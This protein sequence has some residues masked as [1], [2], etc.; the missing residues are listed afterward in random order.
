MRTRVT[1]IADWTIRFYFSFDIYDRERIMQALIWAAA[2]NSLISKV[3]ANIENGRLNEGFCYKDGTRNRDSVVWTRG[4]GQYGARNYTHLPACGR[5]R[6][7]KSVWRGIG[8]PRRRYCA[9]CFRH[10]LRAVLPALQQIEQYRQVGCSIKA[11]R[12]LLRF[13]F[14]ELSL[15]M[16]RCSL[17]GP[18]SWCRNTL[19]GHVRQRRTCGSLCA[20]GRCA[21][22]RSSIVQKAYS[23]FA[24]PLTSGRYAPPPECF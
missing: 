8:L 18:S 17:P 20:S 4:F 5:R 19:S 24:S 6:R 11:P 15:F 12:G 1:R 16:D 3:S 2:P 23:R 22:S 7:N 10:R 14:E 13:S 21:R 9:Q